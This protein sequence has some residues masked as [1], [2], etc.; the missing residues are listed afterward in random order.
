MTKSSLQTYQTTEFILILARLF[1]VISSPMDPRGPYQANPRATH[2]GH[3]A[4]LGTARVPFAWDKYTFVSVCPCINLL[5]SVCSG[6]K[7]VKTVLSSHNND[8]PSYLDLSTKLCNP[9]GVSLRYLVLEFFSLSP[10]GTK[11]S[12]RVRILSS[13]VGHPDEWVPHGHLRPI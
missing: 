12:V 10:M 2:F 11:Y 1:R 6:C 9:C 4:R 13:K 3:L 8:D 5:H 7:P